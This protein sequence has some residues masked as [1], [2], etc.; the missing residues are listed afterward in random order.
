V[1]RWR[2][3]ARGRLGLD[4]GAEAERGVEVGHA[5][6]QRAAG[7]AFGGGGRAWCGRRRRL[8][9]RRWRRQQLRRRAVGVGR[10]LREQCGRWRA[11]LVAAGGQGGVGVGR[12]EGNGRKEKEETRCNG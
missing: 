6:E 12:N 10:G 3:G 11:A 1:G 5:G 9:L 2:R 4:G 8:R 7:V